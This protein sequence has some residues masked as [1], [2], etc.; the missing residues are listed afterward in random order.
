[1]CSEPRPR[2]QGEVADQWLLGSRVFRSAVRRRGARPRAEHSGQ[3]WLGS[4]ESVDETTR[5][6]QEHHVATLPTRIVRPQRSHQ[7]NCKVE[8]ESLALREAIR[9]AASRRTSR[10]ASH[11]IEETPF[12][13]HKENARLRWSARRNPM[14]PGEP[15]RTQNWWPWTLMLP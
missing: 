3:P 4:W 9:N 12:A 8:R 10:A 14:L 15:D 11:S 6:S 7:C 5:S 2:D 13:E 1:M